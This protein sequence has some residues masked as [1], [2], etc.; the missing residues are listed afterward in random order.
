MSSNETWNDFFTHD[1]I[2]ETLQINTL[3]LQTKTMIQIMIMEEFAGE[4]MQGMMEEE[5]K[6]IGK[7][8]YSQVGHD[9][10]KE[11]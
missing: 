4:C 9:L 7:M 5:M 6:G 11:V 1:D 3:I 10:T 2:P 8:L